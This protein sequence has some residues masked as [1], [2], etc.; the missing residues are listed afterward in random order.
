MEVNNE[1]IKA[2]EA[3]G[4][5]FERNIENSTDFFDMVV[6]RGT[7]QHLPHPFSYIEKSY[8]AL[9]KGGCIAF[10]ATPNAN[11]LVYKI[12]NTLP[13][14]D[15]RLNFYIPS[16]I[17][18]CNILENF[19]FKILEVEKPYRCSPYASHFRDPLGFLSC[20]LS[21]RKPDFAFW[22]SMMNIVARKH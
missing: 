7:I 15:P 11:S 1:A 12:F 6:F 2:A 8:D 16:D 13:A 10:L 5:S 21:R 22:G 20:L 19:G 9:R 14:L 4:I 18:L 17:T 3:L